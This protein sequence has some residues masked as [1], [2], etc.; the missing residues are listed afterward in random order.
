MGS[1][2][3]NVLGERKM[4]MRTRARVLWRVSGQQ[5]NLILLE[6]GGAEGT[7]ESLEARREWEVGFERGSRALGEAKWP[8]GPRGRG[9]VWPDLGSAGVTVLHFQMEFVI[10]KSQCPCRPQFVSLNDGSSRLAFALVPTRIS[11][12][13]P[14]E[15]CFPEARV[16]I[17]VSRQDITRWL[18]EERWKNRISNRGAKAR[19][20]ERAMP[21]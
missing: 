12:W 1:P 9:Q 20:G 5:G 3:A 6:Q 19:R 17:M 10:K 2:P 8:V 21:I 13:G 4:A 7:R 15:N 11:Y 18:S 16:K 14:W